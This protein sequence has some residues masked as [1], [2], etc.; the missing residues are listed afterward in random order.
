M[1]SL[2]GDIRI[3]LAAG[4]TDLR[5]G[6]QGLSVLTSSLLAKDPSSG[7]LFVFYNL[8]RTTIKIL[9]YEG[10]GFWLLQKRLA[11]AFLAWILSLQEDRILGDLM[12]TAVGSAAQREHIWPY[13]NPRN[14]NPGPTPYRFFG[15][16]QRTPAPLEFVWSR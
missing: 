13:A 1:L 10:G 4:S 12:A 16:Y 11:K 3:Y 2:T 15:T 7:H 5:K 9:F 14:R 6:I 8:A